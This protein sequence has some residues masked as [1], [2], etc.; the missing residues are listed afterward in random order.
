MKKLLVSLSLFG[1]FW[2]VGSGLLQAQET[3]V[4][5]ACENK[6]DFPNLVGEGDKLD[7]NTPGM[8]IEALRLVEAAM[9]AKKKNIKFNFIRM[10]WKRCMEE[11]KAGS[12]DGIFNASFKEE[13]KEL[14]AYP[15]NGTTVD[16]SRRITTTNYSFYVQKGKKIPWDGKTLGK[17]DGSVG[18][19]AGYSIIDDLKKLGA[20]TE[21]GMEGTKKDFE[22]L[23]AGRLVA[24]AA[25]DK[26]GDH[27][28]KS[29]TAL[30]AKIEKVE[31]A[32]V[33]K[34]YYVMLSHQFVAKNKELAEE[35][36]TELGRIR[37]SEELKA[38]WAL[39]AK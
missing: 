1:F 32:I 26:T 15:M 19:P 3:V 39:Y 18:A 28:L 20:T 38:K 27:I 17:L 33:N 4:T 23:G 22:K 29:D 31:P 30:G 21:E 25:L 10:P 9:K 12:V 14:G 8:S 13:R 34:P 24:A 16:E 11:M 2:G 6:T 5:L 7:A 35:I 37:D 36:W